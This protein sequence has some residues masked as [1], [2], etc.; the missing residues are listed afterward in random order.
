[1]EEE[2]KKGS[3]DSAQLSGSKVEQETVELIKNKY[4]KNIASP[5]INK[6]KNWDDKDHW[7]IPED[8]Q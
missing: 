3:G 4:T 1:M 5:F 6:S 7:A 8:L 2:E